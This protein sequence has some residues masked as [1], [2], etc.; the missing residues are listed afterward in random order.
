MRPFFFVSIFLVWSFPLSAS[1]IAMI[2][3]APDP[4]LDFVERTVEDIFVVGEGSTPSD[5]D[6]STRTVSILAARQV[7]SITAFDVLRN[8]MTSL[9]TVADALTGATASS[10]IVLLT[11][12]GQNESLCALMAALP[13]TAFVWVAGHSAT[14]IDPNVEPSCAAENILRVAPLNAEQDDLIPS[15][16]FGATIRLAARSLSVP[17]VGLGGVVRD[18]SPG[19][20]ASAIAAVALVETANRYPDLRGSELI[21]KL[22]DSAL[23]LPSLEG[24]VE[25][26]RALIE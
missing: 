9:R 26:A 11:V 24:K 3:G 25:G 20:A 5:Q 8:G 1:E 7:T 19:S 14:R 23:Q 4:R 2:A 16:N 13:D 22:L 6:Y 21:A 18:A 17:S 12:G 15:S 10:K